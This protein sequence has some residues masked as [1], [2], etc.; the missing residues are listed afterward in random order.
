MKALVFE[1]HDD[2]LIIGMGGT[3]LK[4]MDNDWEFRTVVMTD[5]RH[6]SNKINPE[7]IVDIRREEKEDEAEYL[8]IEQDR[9]EYEDGK[10]WE[11]MQQNRKEVV[12]RVESI[13]DEFRPDVVFMPSRDEGHP[14][15]RATNLLASRAVYKSDI[16]PLK[17]SYIVWQM[18][19]L[20][21]ENLVE[22]VIRAG[23]DDVY[24]QKLEAVKLH[25]S[26]VEEGRYD[27][28]IESFNSYLGLIY[29]SY[30]ERKGKSEVLGVQNPEKIKK[31]NGIEFEDATRMSHGRS[32]ENIDLEE[33][34]ED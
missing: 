13:L 19:F 27:E 32:T 25:E 6:G 33:V 11:E 29:S 5:G 30:D 12:K 4:M 18:P 10:L 15:H 23:V 34:N 24:D 9:L 14:D 8:G 7:K 21:G 28:I 16:R 3:V 26:Q 22:K 31:L 17:V 1:P 2:D 20:E